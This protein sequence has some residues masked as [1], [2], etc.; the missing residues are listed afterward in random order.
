MN[1]PKN[2]IGITSDRY[3]N[4]GF[5]F[6]REE[7][8]LEGNQEAYREIIGNSIKFMQNLQGG[9]YSGT[10]ESLVQTG[11]GFLAL[12]ENANLGD[13]ILSGDEG[14]RRPIVTFP[15]SGGPA[16]KADGEAPEDPTVGRLDLDISV[17][18]N[19]FDLTERELQ[20]YGSGATIQK[21]QTISLEVLKVLEMFPKK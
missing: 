13:I 21:E 9:V 10:V 3:L 5:F 17:N 19:Y 12:G 6:H 2:P 7:T 18:V 8:N 20:N 4:P 16:V 11:D 15:S 14:S 1:L